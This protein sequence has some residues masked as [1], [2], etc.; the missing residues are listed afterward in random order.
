[1]KIASRSQALK[2][3]QLAE[4]GQQ[5]KRK[6]GNSRNLTRIQLSS[7]YCRWWRRI[8]R[9]GREARVWQ[10]GHRVWRYRYKSGTIGPDTG[11]CVDGTGT[12]A[13]YDGDSGANS[14]FGDLRV[15]GE[16]DS[17]G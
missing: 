1:L 11:G 16:S 6:G 17:S 9:L 7:V 12:V 14:F 4:N 8:W 15:G 2:E 3:Q 10:Q 5:E 13:G